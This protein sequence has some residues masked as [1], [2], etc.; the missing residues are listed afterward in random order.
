MGVLGALATAALGGVVGPATAS[1][2]WHLYNTTS[3]SG[4]T[5]GA[6]APAPC[7]TGH[8]QGDEMRCAIEFDTTRVPVGSKV[9]SATFR[10]GTGET[11]D[12]AQCRVEIRTY[13]GDGQ[14]TYGDL[15]NGSAARIVEVSGPGL[16]TAD[17][18]AFMATLISAGTKYA[19]IRMAS[20]ESGDPSDV[21]TY[22]VANA[23]IDVTYIPTAEVRA[24]WEGAGH[25]TISSKPAGMTCNET[26]C[27]GYF[28]IGK[29]IVLT[30]KPAS[31]STFGAWRFAYCAGQ[32]ATCTFVVPDPG[33][34][35]VVRFDKFV[36]TPTS[37]PSAVSTVPPE[38]TPPASAPPT[39]TSAPTAAS[40][41]AATPA[42][43]F[44]SAASP[45]ATASAGPPSPATEPT[46]AASAAA[47]IVLLVLAVAASV[48][49][50]TILRK[51]RPLR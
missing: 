15:S 22:Y 1:T 24:F 23:R 14:S 2:T 43:P 30:A 32:D 44:A 13:I 41:L 10:V 8:I 37:A 51:G 46:G 50:A 12:C 31:G 16:V 48:A 34:D 38:A 28:E 7:V 36:A 19:G 49:L 5:D 26:V 45:T 11:V 33:A 39:P 42:A 9:I 4:T 6:P 21:I 18:T 47:P 25:G 17:V 40:S 35:V 29:S 27:S 20:L 3:I